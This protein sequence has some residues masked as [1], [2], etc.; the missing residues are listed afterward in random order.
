VKWLYNADRSFYMKGKKG[1]DDKRKLLENFNNLT[2]W[3]DGL[4]GENREIVDH[5]LDTGESAFA[6]PMFLE[7]LTRKPE[8][9]IQIPPLIRRQELP[10]IGSQLAFG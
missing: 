9:R 2:K 6:V 4:K 8:N 1:L 7:Y 5:W 10:L 3:Y